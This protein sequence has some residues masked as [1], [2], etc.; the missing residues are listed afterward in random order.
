MNNRLITAFLLLLTTATGT[1]RLF[2]QENCQNLPQLKLRD[3]VITSAESVPAGPFKLPPG[4]IPS[5]DLPAF[6]RVRGE[7]R[8]S[9]DSHIKFEVWMPLEGWNAKFEQMGNGGLAGSINLLTLGNEMKRGFASAGTDDGHEGQGTDASWALGH[10][11]KIKDFGYRAV[12]ETN[13]KAKQIVAAFYKKPARYAYFNGCSEGGREALMEAQR[14]PTD[15]NGILA[16]APAHYWTELMAAFAWNAQALNDSASFLSPAK[17]SAVE[18]AAIAACGTQDGVADKFIKDPLRCHFDPAVLLCKDADSDTCLTQKQVDAIKKIYAGPINPVTGKQISPGYE[19][20]AEAEPGLPGIATASYIFG[21]GPGLS[22]DAAFSSSFYGGFVFQNPKWSF[23]QLNFERDIATTDEKV[24][25]MLNAADPDLTAL[26]SHGGKLIQYHGWND[27]SPPPLAS[28]NYFQS[29]SAKMGGAAKTRDFYRLFMV[30][31][32]MHCGQGPGPNTF[33]NLFDLA[34]AQ[35]PDRNIFIALQ[36]WVESGVAPDRVV[37]V[38]YKGDDPTK[39]V[40]LSRP[41]CPFPQQAR[42]NGKGDTSDAA[43]WTCSS[44]Y[45]F[46]SPKTLVSK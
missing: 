26:R 9:A 4:L 11:E 41:L 7:I 21:A 29:V 2:A 46:D 22:L 38:K 45:Q 18:N 15:F 30:P 20:G 37:A 43:N 1:K 25:S 19:P 10:P 8:P 23:T 14:F 32:M 16:G 12:H 5:I 3:T 42:W 44:Q 39:G 6:C 40:A 27:G 24:G 33:G 28:V 35:D 13:V 31:G 34:P 36:N 17:R